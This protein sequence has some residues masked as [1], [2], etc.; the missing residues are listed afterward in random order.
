MAIWLL[1]MKT[2]LTDINEDIIILPSVYVLNR[3]WSKI[4]IGSVCI[5]GTLDVQFLYWC[6][7]HYCCS[8]PF[9]IWPR[10]LYPRAPS[11]ITETLLLLA[12]Y[13][14]SQWLLYQGK[15]C[16]GTMKIMYW[17]TL[18]LGIFSVNESYTKFSHVLMYW[19]PVWCHPEYC[20]RLPS[21]LTIG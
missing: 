4:A 3:V 5:I 2:L 18:K 15:T 20:Y 1:I 11:A 16:Y 10:A 6:T 8:S 12:M 13:C 14:I 9:D 19:I 21:K 17:S 7:G